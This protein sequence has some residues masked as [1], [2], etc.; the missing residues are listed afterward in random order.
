MI[1]RSNKSG[2]RSLLWPQL[3]L[4]ALLSLLCW[5][6]SSEKRESD[7]GRIADF[8][9]RRF[10]GSFSPRAR[11]GL[12]IEEP[13]NWQRALNDPRRRRP[14]DADFFPFYVGDPNNLFALNAGDTFTIATS[15]IGG[16][17]LMRIDHLEPGTGGDA[18]AIGYGDD[19]QFGYGTPGDRTS[20]FRPNTLWAGQYSQ[21]KPPPDWSPIGLEIPA[22][23]PLKIKNEEG[24]A[25]IRI[26]LKFSIAT[27]GQLRNAL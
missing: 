13:F 12:G 6:G 10:E 22:G 21:L 15:P 23:A 4:L 8:F 1:S 3:S 26:H 2:R 9:Q 11:E 17:W 24:S 19:S 7:V 27:D 25:Q 20:G 5:G 18:L 16:M 14:R